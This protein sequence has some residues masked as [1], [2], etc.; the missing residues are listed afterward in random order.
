MIFLIEW[1]LLRLC[2]SIP[3]ELSFPQTFIPVGHKNSSHEQNE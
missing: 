3:V 2:L 1:N